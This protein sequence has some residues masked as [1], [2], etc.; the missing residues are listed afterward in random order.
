MLRKALP[1]LV[2]AVFS[3]AA[4]GNYVGPLRAPA[5]SLLPQSAFYGFTSPLSVAESPF[6]ASNPG[7]RFKLGYR[8]N[9]YLSVEGEYV[10][11]RSTANPFSSPGSLSQ[12]FRSTGF[13]ID[14]LATVSVW[15]KLSLYGRFGAYRG[16]ARPDFAPYSTSLA[17]D[18]VRGTRMR[19]GLGLRYDF[20]KSLG[21]RAELERYTPLGHALPTEA[22]SDLLSVGVMWR[23]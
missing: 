4:W 3:S 16:D 14:T 6:L 10:D 9:R 8:A 12:G 11:F 13:G 1:I 20:T 23:F 17:A 22:E 2:L 18:A 21:V 5:S 15:N 19:Y 7:S